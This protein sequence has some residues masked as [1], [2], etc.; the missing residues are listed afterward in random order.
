[1][2]YAIQHI[3]SGQL[4]DYCDTKEQASYFINRGDCELV[5]IAKAA[6]VSVVYTEIY[7]MDYGHQEESF[8][9]YGALRPCLSKLINW[10]KR[11]CRTFGPTIQD[12][13]D[14]FRHCRLY[15]N[16]IDYTKW[17]EKQV[18]KLDKNVVYV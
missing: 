7:Q 13:R 4:I 16:G 1:M 3:G 10:I 2:K 11:T 12:I 8:L 14:F 9:T 17:L 6:K 18:S 15:V 5:E